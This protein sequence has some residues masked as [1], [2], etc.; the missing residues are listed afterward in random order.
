MAPIEAAL[1]DVQKRICRLVL[2]ALQGELQV[3]L[4]FQPEWEW[5]KHGIFMEVA[6]GSGSFL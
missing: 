6:A 3:R 4:P 5:E 1:D 2:E